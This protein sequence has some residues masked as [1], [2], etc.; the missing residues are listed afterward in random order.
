[1]RGWREASTRLEEIL[2]TIDTPAFPSC[3]GMYSGWRAG[4]TAGLAVF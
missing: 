4:L 1:M 3:G 2:R